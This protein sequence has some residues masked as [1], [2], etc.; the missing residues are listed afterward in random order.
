V[1]I[2]ANKRGILPGYCSMFAAGLGLIMAEPDD[3]SVTRKSGI[4]YGAVFAIIISILTFLFIGWLMDRWLGSG[5][6]LVVAGIVLG[7]AIGFYQFIR[8]ISRLS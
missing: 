5:P 6:W 4:V 8:M 7:T 3:E 1:R 2:P